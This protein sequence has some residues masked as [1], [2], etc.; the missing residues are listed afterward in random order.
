MIMK[1]FFLSPLC[2]LNLFLSSDSLK[3]YIYI[4]TMKLLPSYLKSPSLIQCPFLAST[5]LCCSQSGLWKEQ[6]L[7]PTLT[8]IHQW[9]ENLRENVIDFCKFLFFYSLLV[10]RGNL[11]YGKDKDDVC[12]K[13]KTDSPWHAK[14]H[15]VDKRD[16]YWVSIYVQSTLLCMNFW[17]FKRRFLLMTYFWM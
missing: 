12:R 8:S 7:S 2:I 17:M 1:S 15:T 3:L 4:Y 10:N 5:L 9:R 16:R 14:T 11:N 6:P 13:E